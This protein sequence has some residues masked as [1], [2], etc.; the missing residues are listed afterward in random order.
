MTSFQTRG[1][2]IDILCFMWWSKK[3]GTISGT[4]ENLARMVG[5]SKDEFTLFIEEVSTHS[6]ADINVCS[7]GK[8]T[9]TSRRMSRDEKAREQTRLRQKRLRDKSDSN[10]LEADL[11]QESDCVTSALHGEGDGD[12]ELRSSSSK[13][14][15][16]QD[17]EKFWSVYPRKRSKGQAFRAWKTI[18]ASRPSVDEL[19]M[20]VLDQC[21]WHDWIKENGK[22]VPYASTWLNANGWE[23]EIH[24][25]ELSTSELMAQEFKD[26]GY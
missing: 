18:G 21:K 25:R 12:K 8:I 5:A 23:D 14:S 3:K 1:I 2:W 22:Y 17:F 10:A 26:E 13:S 9:L 7:N 20:A 6:F 4:K 15:Y 24:E 16:T 11:S 19:I